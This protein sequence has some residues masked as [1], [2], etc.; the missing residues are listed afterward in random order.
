MAYK[1]CSFL[2]LLQSLFCSTLRSS[3]S[4]LPV[5]SFSPLPFH[6]RAVSLFFPAPLAASLCLHPHPC[7]SRPP[8]CYLFHKTFHLVLAASPPLLSPSLSP[9]M[10]L[11]LT[12]T[13]GTRQRLTK[14]QAKLPIILITHNEDEIMN[15]V[16][17]SGLFWVTAITSECPA[18]C[19]CVDAFSGPPLLD[20]ILQPSIPRGFTLGEAVHVG[21]N[22][23]AS[24]RLKHTVHQSPF[25]S[26]ECISCPSCDLRHQCSL[27]V[28]LVAHRFPVRRL[29]LTSPAGFCRGVEGG[30]QAQRCQ[31]S[32]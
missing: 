8:H 26:E 27:T 24:E 10:H 3:S 2:C 15:G 9:E 31:P 14:V 1:G 23:A 16:F 13:S 20:S 11:L 32:A 6:P 21:I 5:P 17:E 4:P 29:C 22:Q 18:Y 12:Y 25:C 7:L 19:I 30:L 28:E